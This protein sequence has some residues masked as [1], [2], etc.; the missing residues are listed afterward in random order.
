MPSPF[1]GMNPYLETD[2][3]WHDFHEK[4]GY[5]DYI[6]SGLPQPPLQGEDLAWV[7]GLVPHRFA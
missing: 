5:E 1:P 2:D 4:V 6:D 7:E 3:A